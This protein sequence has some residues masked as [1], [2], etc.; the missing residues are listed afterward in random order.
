[1]DKA[2]RS[3]RHKGF[4]P[5]GGTCGG[6]AVGPGGWRGGFWVSVFVL[7][8]DLHEPSFHAQFYYP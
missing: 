7:L 6:L 8:I 2:C 3:S 4:Q 1:M 5:R